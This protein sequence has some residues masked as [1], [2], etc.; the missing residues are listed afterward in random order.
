[1]VRHDSDA[2]SHEFVQTRG[3]NYRFYPIV[4]AGR[5]FLPYSD[6]AEWERDI[7]IND[8]HIP[9]RGLKPFEQLRQHEAALIH[10][11]LRLNQYSGR[12]ADSDLVGNH[13]RPALLTNANVVLTGHPFDNPKP[14]IVIRAFVLRPGIPEADHQPHA[15]LWIADCGLRI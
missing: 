4:A 15:G 1:M 8:D 9:D 10:I 2:N 3:R 12:T 5:T 13:C 6:L 14:D 7:V 11:C